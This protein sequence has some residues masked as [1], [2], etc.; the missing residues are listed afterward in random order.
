MGKKR[1][2]HLQFP[3]GGLDRSR[4]YRKQPPFTT[5]D[6][7]NVRPFENLEGRGRGGSR[8]GLD[9]AFYE[10]LGSGNPIRML[11]AVSYLDSTG[12]TYWTDK[13]LGLSLGAGWTTASWLSDAP[14]VLEWTGVAS[15]FDTTVGA[16][17]DAIDLDNTEDYRVEL[18]IRPWEGEHHGT[19]S[20]FARMDDAAPDA[21][22]GGIVA[23]LVL[24]GVEG[25]YSGTL[26]VDG[27]TTYRF[28]SG[29]LEYPGPG[30]FRV[31]I[32]GNTV[33]CYWREILLIEQV[34]AAAT[35][36][37]VGFGM[38]CTEEGGMCRTETFRVQYYDS[39]TVD[40]ERR[41]RI[42]V[43]S[44]NGSVYREGWLGQMDLLAVGPALAS[45]RPIQAAERTQKLY[46]A[47]NGD[48]RV[49]GTDGVVA[50][51]GTDLT[52][53]SVADWT[54]LGI[55]P[56]SDVCVFS[57]VD[58]DA[59]GIVGTYPIQAV[60]VTKLV[61]EDTGGA[62]AT[63][64]YRIERGPKVYDP[65]DDSL[66]MWTATEELGELPT[67]CALVALYRDR[68][69]LVRNHQWFMSRMGDPLDWNYGAASTDVK[70]AISGG[71]SN[72][73]NLAQNV[74]ALV[75]FSD[76]NL[77]FGHE[78]ELWEMRGDPAA[79]GRIDNVS[80]IY[81]I[82]GANA[83]CVTPE[84]LLVALSRDGLWKMPPRGKPE[85]MSRDRLPREL[86][87]ID[88]TLYTPS[89]AYD[90]RD[91]GIHVYL[92]PNEAKGQ[93]HFWFDWRAQ[94]FWPVDLQDGHEPT[95]LFDHSSQATEEAAV[96]HGGRDGYIR[97]Y[98]DLSAT[99]DGSRIDSYVLYG[100]IAPG[101][102]DYREGFVDQLNAFLS[103][104]GGGVLWSLKYGATTEAAMNATATESGS[105]A[106]GENPVD[107]PMRRAP[108]IFLRLSGTTDYRAW[109]IEGITAILR[110]TGRRRIL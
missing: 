105:W 69:V 67:G 32:S 43:A 72:A 31:V 64:T 34:V 15:T 73:G 97:R 25:E 80:R 75:P 94:S 55:D 47:D 81:G 4:A 79:G 51:N 6:A 108:W 2:A 22:A 68:L 53:A 23:T 62:I 88:L 24:T 92:T 37:R 14:S 1:L 33:S 76:A 63:A 49:S 100:P 87:D 83:W 48:L 104:A 60:G 86:I 12:L 82:T 28:S 99:D 78:T 58:D 56:D 96:L 20:I 110:T 50:A 13:F 70:R 77:I 46:L 44:A 11:S 38:A 98:S 54:A 57:A 95:A 7:L 10:E 45:D 93:L 61:I 107:R 16:V 30:W 40:A 89:L 17:R 3:L 65:S 102:A 84:G 90:I 91:K 18:E 35:G 19:Y 106:A 41:R 21:S 52:A 36:D 66:V 109:A 101:E 74:T 71:N 59:T 5:P 103:T 8:P 39:A 42:V 27:S 85:P 9:K 29:R 26:V